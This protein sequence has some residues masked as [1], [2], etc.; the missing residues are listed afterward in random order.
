MTKAIDFLCTIN[1]EFQNI[2]E[3]V[4]LK[5]PR[6]ACI[7]KKNDF[8]SEDMKKIYIPILGEKTKKHSKHVDSSTH[9]IDLMQGFSASAYW[10]CVSYNCRPASLTSTHSMPA[11]LPQVVDNQS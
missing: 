9:F 4:N 6:L 1:Y 8:C 2:M 7:R 3:E 5:Y 10:Q 11:A